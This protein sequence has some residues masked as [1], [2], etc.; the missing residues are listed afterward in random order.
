VGPLPAELVDR[1]AD[2]TMQNLIRYV[3]AQLK[4]EE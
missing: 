4:E 1:R 3:R 2:R